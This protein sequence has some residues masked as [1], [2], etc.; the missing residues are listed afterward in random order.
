MS[1]IGIIIV[2]EL[3]MIGDASRG[4]LLELLLTKVIY[5]QKTL[6]TNDL[7]I[8]GM[9]ATIPNLPDVA[10]WLN[11]E[12]YITNYRPVP[13]YERI[14]NENKLLDPK[15]PT[16][17]EIGSIDVTNLG[18]NTPDSSLVF[19]AI[20]TLVDGFSALV[21]CSTRS[22]CESV[23][24]VIAENI[25]EFGAKKKAHNDRTLELSAKVS[26]QIKFPK[27]YNLLQSLKRT[28]TGLDKNL[29]L[30][31]RFGVAFHHAGLSI[32]ERAL[33]E[34]SF[35]DGTIRILC[36]TTTLSAGVNLPAR[37]VLIC[38]PFDYRGSLLDVITYQQ[39]IG[40]AGRKN[41]DTLGESFL[42]CKQKDLNQSLTLVKSSLRPVKSKLI[43]YVN[44]NSQDVS[45]VDTGHESIQRAILEVIANETVSTFDDLKLYFSSTFFSQNTTEFDMCTMFESVIGELFTKNLINSKSN[46]EL[47]TTPLGMAVIASGVSPQD[48]VFIFNE[49]DKARRK[50][51]LV[52]DL[53]L[54]YEVTPTYF[55]SQ[56]DTIDWNNY[57]SIFSKLDKDTRSVAELIGVNESFLVSRVAT[58]SYLKPSN[59]Q[60]TIHLRFYASLA[61]Y[62]LV[63]EIPLLTVVKKYHLSKGLV[64]SLQQQAA[65]F[66]GM[67]TTFCSKLGWNSM[68][69]LIEQ[70]QPRLSF[71]VQ[72]DLIDLM[73]L[74]CINSTIAR[75]LYNSG[76]EL[77]TSLISCQANQ[78][79]QILLKSIPF[80]VEENQ[81]TDSDR[82]L[83]TIYIAN[84]DQNIT[85]RD[86]SSLIIKESRS[87]VESDIGQKLTF[88]NDVLAS[89]Q[90]KPISVDNN[91][92]I[93]NI[94]NG[95]LD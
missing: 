27:I 26:Q 54:I 38:S 52:N 62:D 3:H 86:L 25:F 88:T 78:I 29:E 49:L 31:V 32:E 41:I 94:A 35:R 60:L 70:F 21:F 55:V 19:S 1:D 72:R 14:V 36:S 83:T 17:M 6:K 74:P 11:A 85:I 10:K 81:T 16:D 12:L 34:N 23:S 71:G 2:D 5:L 45:N 76:Y 53:H 13:L 4:Y 63:R 91:V 56:L 46:T 58:W 73:R 24:K 57:M 28:S 50:L 18:I 39:M 92:T 61:L 75:M 7:Q 47:K 20:E 22:Q 59:V 64:Q 77:L 9:S 44:N 30:V 42:F 33:I 80:S 82:G 15:E 79:E 37:R 8:V 68:E 66:A 48:G 89:P 51:C 95:K 69:L 84:I 67:L 87:L 93:E 90:S 65:T 43:K 40:R